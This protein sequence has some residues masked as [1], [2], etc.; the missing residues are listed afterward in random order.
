V[1]NKYP[2]VDAHEVVIES[3]DH[4]ADLADYEIPHLRGVLGLWRERVRAL[5]AEPATAAALVFRN[6]GRRAGSSQPHPHTQIAATSWVPAEVRLR[7]RIAQDQER[8]LGRSLH[9]AVLERELAS[10]RVL[11][12]DPRVVSF[13]PYAPSRPFE[14]RFAPREARGGFATAEDSDLDSLA[15]QLRDAALRLRVHTGIEDYN[16]VMRQPPARERGPAA[17]WHLELLPRTG[18]DAGFELATGEMIVVV[19]PEVAAAQLMRP[20]A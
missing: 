15:A 17:A 9:A 6:R 13:C 4:D 11:S 16:L 3:P 1:A 8:E 5:E 2:A 12:S 14:L 19:A 20:L 10:S 18:G 7:W